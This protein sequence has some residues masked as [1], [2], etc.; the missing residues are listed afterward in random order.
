MPGSAVLLE[1]WL[2]SFLARLLCVYAGAACSADSAA[3]VATKADSSADAG[4]AAG[5]PA[6][7]H[8]NPDV[9]TLTRLV[10]PEDEIEADK[11]QVRW[12]HPLPHLLAASMGLC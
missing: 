1:A 6:P 3:T 11:A 2:T 7:L 4:A 9:Y 10:A 12:P 5:G 8:F